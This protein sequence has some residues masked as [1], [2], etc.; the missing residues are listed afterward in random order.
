VAALT[1]GIGPRWSEYAGSAEAIGRLA[2]RVEALGFDAIFVGDH[3]SFHSPYLDAFVVLSIAAAHTSRLRLQTSVLILPLYQPFRLANTAAT[4]DVASGGR[5]ILG[6]G[7]GGEGPKDFAAVEVPMAER[8]AR[9]DEILKIL[10]RLWAEE[11]EV[12]VDGKFYRLDGVRLMVRPARPGGP[13]LWVGGRSK[14][15]IRRAAMLGDAW[16]GIWVSPKRCREEAERIAQMAGAAGRPTGAVS[17]ALQVWGGLAGSREEA[18]DRVAAI[19]QRSYNLPL[20]A[21]ERYVFLGRDEDW[22]QQIHEYAAAGVTRFNLIPCG[23]DY[24]EQLE[25][26]ARA[27]RLARGG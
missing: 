6:V 7:V 26:A 25:R 13:P 23:P 12:T 17:L 24:D 4:L 5:L 22:A 2:A 10:R 1:F 20:E 27:A 21:F 19:M 8:G 18:R 3:L 16:I 9:A 14:A 15:A 11:G